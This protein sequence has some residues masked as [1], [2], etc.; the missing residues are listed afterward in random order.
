MRLFLRRRLPLFSYEDKE[1]QVHPRTGHD[2]PERKQTY[3]SAV[4]ATSTLGEAAYW[5]NFAATL[6][7]EKRPCT[8]C[9]RQ[10]LNHH[11]S[12]ATWRGVLCVRDGHTNHT[13]WHDLN[14]QWGLMLTSGVQ[15]TLQCVLP[16]TSA[17]IMTSI[18]GKLKLI[19][20]PLSHVVL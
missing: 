10:K 1:G 8:H 6:P 18:Y 16:V 17:V 4:S 2:G 13:F 14:R 9:R 20:G 15:V 5:H 3:S 12:H 7:R 19:H 11:V